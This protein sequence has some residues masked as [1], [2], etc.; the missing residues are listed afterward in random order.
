MRG[1][2]ADDRAVSSAVATRFVKHIAEHYDLISAEISSALSDFH[3]DAVE[4]GGPRQQQHMGELSCSFQ[5][6]LEYARS[7]GAIDDVEIA[8]WGLRLQNALERALAANMRLT[9]KFERENVSNIAKII[10][11]AMKSETILLAKS[12]EKFSKK[13]DKYAGF[14]GRKRTVYIRLSSLQELLT[15]VSGKVWTDSAVGQ[16]AA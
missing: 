15:S 10:V 13:P 12:K 3:A 9:A 14:E 8:E 7:I 4:E 1:K 11:D 5:L 2:E 6:L 16:A